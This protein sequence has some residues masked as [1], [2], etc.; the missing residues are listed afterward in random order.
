MG[1]ALPLRERRLKSHGKIKTWDG[2]LSSNRI[3]AGREPEL[4]SSV[5]GWDLSG[6]GCLPV[7]PHHLS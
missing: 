7:L 1:H 4:S 6:Y 2:G 3:S 5:S